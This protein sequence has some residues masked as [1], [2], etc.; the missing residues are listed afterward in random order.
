MT[1]SLSKIDFSLAVESYARE[2]DVSLLEACIIIAE[3]NDIEYN[4]I[5][6]YIYQALYD[7]IEIEAVNNKTIR[8]TN[9]NSL[10]LLGI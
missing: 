2:N 4:D 1:C 3:E 9:N 5:P 10:D 7:K 6:K 8:K